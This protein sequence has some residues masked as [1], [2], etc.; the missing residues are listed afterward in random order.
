MSPQPIFS[1]YQEETGVS[2]E[3]MHTSFNMGMGFA[4]LVR[5]EDCSEVIGIAQENGKE[6]LI[7]GEV[8]ESSE[9]NSTTILHKDGN[10]I[11]FMG[12]Q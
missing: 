12:Y 6:A 9:Q 10:E 7:I 8:R 11:T 3:K 1:L 5:P 4:A 2:I